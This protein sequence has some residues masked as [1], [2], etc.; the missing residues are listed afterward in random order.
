M[1]LV[2]AACFGIALSIAACGD[3]EKISRAAPRPSAQTSSC[4]LARIE[5]HADP[6]VVPGAFLLDEPK[7]E[8]AQTFDRRQRVV[9]TLNVKGSVQETF[10]AYKATIPDSPFELLQ[11]DNEGF[12]AEIYLQQ[13]NDFAV[14]QIRASRCDDASLVILNL[15]SA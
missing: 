15:P 2:L 5:P 14:I 3:D 12:E 8:V 1:S 4:G 9:A 11:I 13:G 6:S 7:V 10:R